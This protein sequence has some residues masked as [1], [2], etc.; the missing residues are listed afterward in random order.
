M[1]VVTVKVCRSHYS[2]I[3]DKKGQANL[4]EGVIA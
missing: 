1:N 3:I 4:S 2:A